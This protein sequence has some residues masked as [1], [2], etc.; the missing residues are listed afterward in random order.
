VI[1]RDGCEAPGFAAGRQLAAPRSGSES[2]SANREDVRNTPAYLARSFGLWVSTGQTGGPPHVGRKIFKGDTEMKNV[3]WVESR[4]GATV[5]I[6][7]S[8][9]PEGWSFWEK[10]AGEDR[11][12]FPIESTPVL[13]ARAEEEFR[14][15]TVLIAQR[16]SAAQFDE[17]ETELMPLPLAA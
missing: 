2:G 1:G 14:T 3:E 7:A 8:E 6:L 16:R 13:I 9:K 4:L 12:W 17:L 5:R 11:R 10:E 15:M